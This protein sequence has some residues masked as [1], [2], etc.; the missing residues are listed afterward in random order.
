MQKSTTQITNQTITKQ[1]D[2]N[3]YTTGET[4]KSHFKSMPHHFGIIVG[5]TTQGRPVIEMNSGGVEILMNKEWIKVK[6]TTYYVYRTS[7]WH[8]MVTEDSTVNALHTFTLE[9]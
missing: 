6:K 9:E 4:W 2:G 5:F 3:T 1:C 7:N 8:L